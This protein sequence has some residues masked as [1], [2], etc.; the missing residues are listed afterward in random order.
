MLLARRGVVPSSPRA[1]YAFAL[2]CWCACV[3]LGLL[4]GAPL[5]SDEAAYALLARGVDDAW[6]YRPVGIVAVA[7][8]G[9]LLGDSD[10]AVRFPVAL[11][12]PL[13]LVAV[14]ALGRRFGPWT[15]AGAPLML[16]TTHQVVLRAPELL[17]D[18]PSTTCL[19][20]AIVLIIDE[21][22]RD[23]GPRY[24]LVTAAPLL[25]AA[26]YLRY[27]C[28]PVILLIVL[29]AIA[30]WR[31][32]VV[33]RPGPIVITAVVFAALLAPFLVYSHRVTG[34]A[35][36][37]LQ[38]ASELAPRKYLG[39]GLWHF[40]RNNPFRQY[41]VALAPVMVL[42]L[43]SIAKPPPAQRR[44]AAWFLAIVAIG[45]IV[46]IGIV[47]HASTRMVFLALALLTVLGVDLIER[48]TRPGRARCAAAIVGVLAAAVMVTMMVPLE[49]RMTRGL[50]STVAA[51]RAIRTDAAGRACT[52]IARA[53]PQLMWYSGCASRKIRQPAEPVE[54]TADTRWYAANAPRRPVDPVALGAA[55]RAEV[56]PLLVPGAWRL[57][58]R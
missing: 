16:A 38:M 26:F 20:A 46:L 17:N 47:S 18:I 33:A 12:S 14:A 29:A 50:A 57:E 10:L 2:A 56:T 1:L 24:R 54:L 11:A 52:V 43:A 58:P 55:C 4:A 27:G 5:T 32:A 23:P 44:A 6:L 53:T 9:A 3:V 13:L 45:Q 7:R 8:V 37:I 21:L 15:A 40:V 35:L 49:R 34:S 22:D 39:D 30:I 51:A 28:A 36:G 41:G 48:S 25:A 31:R 42:G 19:V